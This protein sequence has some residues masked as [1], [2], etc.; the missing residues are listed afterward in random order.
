[1]F[2]PDYN[3]P[4]KLREL[5]DAQ[6]LAMRKR[7]GQNFLV[8]PAARERIACAL[9]ISPGATVWEIGAGLGSLTRA[10]LDQDALV[11]AFEIDRGFVSL[12]E[13]FF[14]PEQK[15]GRFSLIAGDVLKT[16]RPALAEQ[17][18]PE[19][20]CGNLPYIIAAALIG[21]TIEAGIRFGRCVFTVQKEVA[22]RMAAKPGTGEYSAFSALCQWAYRV[23]A[24]F[25]LAPGNFWP[26]PE[27]TST[28]VL[29]EAGPDF[30]GCRDPARFVRLLRA[31][32]AS[33]RKTLKNNLSGFFGGP[34]RL[35]SLFR[36]AGVNPGERAENLGVAEFLRLCE[37]E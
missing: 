23:T 19:R 1:M 15:A 29:L 28:V 9:G 22:A 31:S 17:G 21:D 2:L 24:L 37:A 34:E 16:W 4:A 12:L 18:T 35:E 36:N 30:P 32:F 6:G 5:L 3:S 8:N 11:T 13:N 26:R 33:R 10:L 25:D 27:V 20:F 7:F 14:E